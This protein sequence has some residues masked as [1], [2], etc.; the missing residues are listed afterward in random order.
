[1]PRALSRAFVSIAIII[2]CSIE[3]DRVQSGRGQGPARTR[4]S[5]LVV[6]WRNAALRNRRC[7]ARSRVPEPCRQASPF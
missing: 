1:M 3:I 2:L 7:P 4:R 6:P 5:R